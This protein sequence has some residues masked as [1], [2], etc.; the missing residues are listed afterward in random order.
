MKKIV[1]K[2]KRQDSESVCLRLNPSCFRSGIG[3]NNCNIPITQSVYKIIFRCK[4]QFC[5][6]I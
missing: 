1:G 5:N 2:G 6:I 4:T 3:E